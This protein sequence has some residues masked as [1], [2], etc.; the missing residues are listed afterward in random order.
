LKKGSKRKCEDISKKVR[1]WKKQ[2][3]ESR[4]RR[5]E[6]LKTDQNHLDE[7][8]RWLTWKWDEQSDPSLLELLDKSRNWWPVVRRRVRVG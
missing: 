8:F 4:S 3:N 5:Q 7:P 1:K 2:K 6:R